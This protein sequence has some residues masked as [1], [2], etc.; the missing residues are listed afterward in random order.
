MKF[1]FSRLTALST[2]LPAY[3]VPCAFLQGPRPGRPAP[4]HPLARVSR[5]GLAK[6]L[7]IRKGELSRGGNLG[8]LEDG[9]AGFARSLDD[10][11]EGRGGSPWPVQTME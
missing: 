3:A 2:S 5:V 9:A 8:G 7:E 4:F 11:E 6:P 10:M 1:F